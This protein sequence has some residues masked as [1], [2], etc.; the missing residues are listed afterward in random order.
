MSALL[1][2]TLT[3]VVALVE[4]RVLRHRSQP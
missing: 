3:S 1:G 2:L 4:R